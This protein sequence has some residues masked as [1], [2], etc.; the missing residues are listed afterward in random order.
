M[1]KKSV[2]VILICVLLTACPPPEGESKIMK[3]SQVSVSPSFGFAGDEF[4]FKAVFETTTDAKLTVEL[5]D[6]IG[7][8]LRDL[9]PVTVK[10]GKKEFNIKDNVSETGPIK[11]VFSLNAEG[12]ETVSKSEWFQVYNQSS[13][14][15]EFVWVSPENKIVSEGD[16]VS[17]DMQ[18]VK[19][20]SLNRL[21][22]VSAAFTAQKQR[23]DGTWEPAPD[24]FTSFPEMTAENLNAPVTLTVA[25]EPEEGTL[26]GLYRL[27]LTITNAAT[28]T[29]IATASKSEEFTVKAVGYPSA[30]FVLNN[31]QPSYTQG[32]ILYFD[33]SSVTADISEEPSA[34]LASAAFSLEKKNGETWTAIENMTDLFSSPGE[35]NEGNL[36]DLYSLTLKESVTEDAAYRLIFTISNSTGKM[37]SKSVELN[38]LSG[39][40]ILRDGVRYTPVFMKTDF[41]RDAEQTGG[42]VTLG[43]DGASFS[44]KSLQ[45]NDGKTDTL[46]ITNMTGLDATP[47]NMRGW[48][49]E[50]KLSYSNTENPGACIWFEEGT[51]DK[52]RFFRNS[53]GF[54]FEYGADSAAESYNV[55]ADQIFSIGYQ[56][57]HEIKQ[58]TSVFFHNGNKHA[59][60]LENTGDWCINNPAKLNNSGDNSFTFVLKYDSREP[61]DEGTL[62]V[63]QVTVYKPKS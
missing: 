40:D 22:L 15:P 35:I 53:S 49:M 9:T 48:I 3:I 5:Q 32:D 23:E 7:N 16:S 4:T 31:T 21:E 55:Y 42:H 2:F 45:T 28:D 13:P 57:N 18:N 52:I 36:T 43:T 27:T 62:T 63:K 34:T 17:I 29:G 26:S 56:F 20:D 41:S 1:C 24:I 37:K 50:L 54:K 46:K 33:M 11:A 44:V 58:G 6:S 51:N 47:D 60:V 39:G 25:P 61:A 30:E 10:A 19:A 8:K 14:L 38:V 59:F 12:A